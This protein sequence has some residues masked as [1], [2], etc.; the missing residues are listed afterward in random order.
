[1]KRDVRIGCSE[2]GESVY[3]RVQ[4]DGKRQASSRF[5]SSNL[6]SLFFTWNLLGTF[7]LFFLLFLS[8]Y[9]LLTF[10]AHYIP[11]LT[12]PIFFLILII[13]ISCFAN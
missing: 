4:E 11:S 3:R 8:L 9:Y 5:A 10:R 2:G 13:H 12:H 6:F 7:Y 1:M